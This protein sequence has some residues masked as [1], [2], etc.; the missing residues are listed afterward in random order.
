MAV[1]QTMAIIGRRH[2][3]RRL[4]EASGATIMDHLSAEAVITF[5]DQI[6]TLKGQIGIPFY[7]KG[8]G[9]SHDLLFL[10]GLKVIEDSGK[11]EVPIASTSSIPGTLIDIE[12]GRPFVPFANIYGNHRRPIE[13]YASF[14]VATKSRLQY[15]SSG[16]LWSYR[17]IIERLMCGATLTAVH[18]AAMYKG[19]GV[20]EQMKL[21][22]I[23]DLKILRQFWA[24]RFS[25]PWIISGGTIF[26]L[27][28]LL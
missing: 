7:I 19:Y 11:G 10:K 18:T 8:N 22:Y 15:M 12:S 5:V 28:I 3:R 26:I 25:I 16:G 9:Y 21:V 14:L 20:F 6:E 23:R 24:F 4:Q 17:D 2:R 27:K 1:V 13:C